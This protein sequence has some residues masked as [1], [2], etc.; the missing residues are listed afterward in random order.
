MLQT[1]FFLLYEK[2]GRCDFFLLEEH[3]PR[4]VRLS[5]GNNLVGL[6]PEANLT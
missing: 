6:H 1:L 4:S 3:I 5:L 2:L